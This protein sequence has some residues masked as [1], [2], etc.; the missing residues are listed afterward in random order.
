MCF[1]IKRLVQGLGLSLLTTSSVA[2]APVTQPHSHQAQ[3]AWLSVSRILNDVAVTI[4]EMNGLIFTRSF[5]LSLAALTEP[6]LT[7]SVRERRR[8]IAVPSTLPC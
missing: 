3:G 4:D 1:G 8:S 2:A 5:A 6:G 7:G